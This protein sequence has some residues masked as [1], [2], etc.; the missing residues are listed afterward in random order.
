VVAS[1]GISA[2]GRESGL[3]VEQRI[4]SV[5]TVQ[6]GRIVRVRGYRTEADALEAAGLSE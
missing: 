6:G 3:V 2:R 5:W 1:M 4:S